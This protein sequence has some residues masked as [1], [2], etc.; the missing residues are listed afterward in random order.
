MLMYTSFFRPEISFLGKFGPKNQNCLFWMKF[1]TQS[2]LNLYVEFDGDVHFSVLD[3]KY[4]DWQI[5]SK[6]SKF[7]FKLKLGSQTNSNK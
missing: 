3:H 2:N 5:W 1:A 6:N 4:P 7:M